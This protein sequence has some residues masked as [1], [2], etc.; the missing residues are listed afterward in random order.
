MLHVGA[1]ERVPA[2]VID[3]QWRHRAQRRRR[4]HERDPHRLG[5]LRE[6]RAGGAGDVDLDVIGA[7]PP[8]WSQ[9]RLHHQLASRLGDARREGCVERRHQ[10][11]AERH[12]RHAGVGERDAVDGGDGDGHRLGGAV[13]AQLDGGGGLLLEQRLRVGDLAPRRRGDDEREDDATQ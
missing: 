2:D 8:Q 11:V 13:V 1:A 9:G 10:T 12:V 4:Q 5:H 3:H 7:A 6:Q